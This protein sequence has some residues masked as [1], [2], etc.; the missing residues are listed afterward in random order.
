MKLVLATNNKGKVREMSEMLASCGIEVLSLADF[1][2][3][4]DIEE[5]GDTFQANAVKKAAITAELTG[6]TA[7]ADDSGLEVDYLGGAPGVYSARFAGEEKSDRANNE[8]LLRLLAGLPP[9]KRAARFQCVM[10]IARPGGFVH[11]VQGTCE[12]VI[13][14]EPRGDMGFGYDPLFYLP[15][16]DKT[17]AELDLSVKNKISHRGK[18]L[19]QVLEYLSELSKKE[20]D[21]G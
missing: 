11:T 12:G 14:G 19:A 8:K 4:G 21:R 13:A 18:A 6:L 5:D 16:Y 9:D 17:F 15:D 3:V 1:P 10:A 20:I 2:Q 7:L